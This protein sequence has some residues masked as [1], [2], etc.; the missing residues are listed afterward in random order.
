MNL[1]CKNKECQYEWDYKGESEFY[2]TCPRCLNKVKVREYVE[3]N[4]YCP[5]SKPNKE[6]TKCLSCNGKNPIIKKSKKKSK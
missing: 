3:G 6:G 5:I 1:K 4:C 2:A